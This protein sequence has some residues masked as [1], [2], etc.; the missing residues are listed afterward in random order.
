MMGIRVTMRH[1]RAAKIGGQGVLC[2]PGVRP[3]FAQHGLDYRA[4]LR[5][6]LPVEQAEALDDAF[7]QR[8][9]AIARE[10]AERG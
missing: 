10:E 3:W 2:A 1:V 7:A 8:A 4:F 9:A 6:G 5:E